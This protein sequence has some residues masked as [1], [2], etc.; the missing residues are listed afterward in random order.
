MLRRGGAAWAFWCVIAFA[1]DAFAEV[2]ELPLPCRFVAGELSSS[3]T[4]QLA[5]ARRAFDSEAAK[6]DE[7]GICGR[8][9][10][11][12]PA[13][14]A[15]LVWLRF[16]TP[17]VAAYI[18]S[19]VEVERDL[20]EL[21]VQQGL[22]GADVSDFDQ[23]LEARRIFSVPATVSG[24]PD[25]AGRLAR[26]GTAT[27]ELTRRVEAGELATALATAEE[28]LAERVSLLGAEHP[29]A[30]QSESNVAFLLMELARLEQ[31][32]PR[33][34]HALEV[35]RRTLGEADAETAVSA[36]NV[37]T[38]LQLRGDF[39]EAEELLA[40]A[41]P[42]YERVYGPIHPNVA[43]VRSLASNVQLGLGRLDAARRSLEAGVAALNMVQGRRTV[44]TLQLE[45]SLG[46]LLVELG[47]PVE[48]LKVLERALADG[49][50]G[51]A[52]G[53]PL[54][55][56]LLHR[57]AQ[58][59]SDLG[60]L[61]DAAGHFGESIEVGRAAFGEG[62]PLV[63]MAV[64]G[65]AMV[66][67]RAGRRAEARRLYEVALERGR[68]ALGAE[69]W[70]VAVYETAL[71][72]M[73]GHDGESEAAAKLLGH[74]LSIRERVLGTDH[75]HVAETL[76][77]LGIV[78]LARGHREEG[79][80]Q[81]QRAL[82]IARLHLE[83]NLQAAGSDTALLGFAARTR[84]IVDAALTAYLEPGPD[85]VPD[86]AAAFE[87]LL[88]WQGVGTLLEAV[89]RD[90]KR[91]FDA[92]KTD[93]RSKAHWDQLRKLD[94][95]RSALEAA[96]PAG[97]STP[98]V[99]K[100]GSARLREIAEE[101]EEALK[102]LLARVP[103]LSSARRPLGASAEAV[104]AALHQANATLLDYVQIRPPRRRLPTSDPHAPLEADAEPAWLDVFGVSANK[105]ASGKVTCAVRW[106]RLGTAAVIHEE[107]RTLRLAIDSAS[108]CDGASCD[109]AERAVDQQLKVVSRRLVGPVQGWLE[110]ESDP[111][112]PGPELWV[113][114]DGPLS[115]LPF[116]IMRFGARHAVERF[117]VKHL[118]YPAAAVAA[119]RE[120]SSVDRALV[121]G[122]LDYTRS[123]A[124]L[125]ETRCAASGCVAPTDRAAHGGGEL[126]ASWARRSAGVCGYQSKWGDLTPT[127]ASTV[128]LRLG[129]SL[130]RVGLIT[131]AGAPES[132]VAAAMPGVRLLHFATHGFFSPAGSCPAGASGAIFDPLRQSA[133]VLSGANTRG[134]GGI[135]LDPSADGLLTARDIADL[136]LGEAQ[137]VVLSACETALGVP[138]AGEGVLGL[139]R[140]FGVA[141]VGTTIASWWEIPN[142]ET[143]ELFDHFYD[144]LLGG[145][146]PA[147]ALR[148]AQLD[149]VARLRAD[150]GAA[151]ITLWG[152]FVPLVFRD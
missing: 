26:T 87:V 11:Q 132:A 64:H 131:G 52:P 140:A 7:L 9:C 18:A 35:R 144:H 67:D 86:A 109:A 28:I 149:I 62:H 126:L 80:A 101:R 112:R 120:R 29:L 100:G 147:A 124:A 122:D 56:L 53:H 36:V 114:P 58:A 50:A 27:T 113:V 106:M 32:E 78:T 10:A 31:A 40:S 49:R 16:G 146:S 51:F 25:R 60:R 70:T 133:V 151:P 30:A 39:A 85:A 95:E 125:E 42:I 135:G 55:A 139:S 73:L 118:P 94:R 61:D 69:H 105:G 82:R 71:G 38:L 84:T 96:A 4:F 76:G 129:R 15:C 77:Q 48:A 152:A 23:F 24:D 14:Q 6:A 74:A 119:R 137:L 97:A 34:R 130:N 104:C 134:P 116:G 43:A 99:S 65:L 91:L 141:G 37:A 3:S 46:A 2:P 20:K 8:W 111:A 121:I 92:P 143:S 90:Q 12:Q 145:Q 103:G 83:R 110:G 47:D 75:S 54:N 89:W 148:K 1:S 41:V 79:R 19:T 98:A 21:A 68:A 66:L 44:W 45:A 5:P 150:T 136:P 81:L 57:L 138:I 72:S 142:D 63:A 93:A 88:S 127:E 117:V 108:R 17:G 59:E 123:E 33:L 102:Q 107:V 13:S 128:A 22:T 115:E